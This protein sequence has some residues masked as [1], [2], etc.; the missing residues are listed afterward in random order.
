[1]LTIQTLHLAVL[2]EMEFNTLYKNCPL[3]P[4]SILN[5]RS[6]TVTDLKV[7]DRDKVWEE[8]KDV[9]NFEQVATGQTVHGFLHVFLLL[10][11]MPRNLQPKLFPQL[12]VIFG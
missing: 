6:Y 11:D 4:S 10:H 2:S 1:M 8:W 3:F 9:F 7:V 12:L 5:P